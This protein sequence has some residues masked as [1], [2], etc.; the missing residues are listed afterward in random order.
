M[1]GGPSGV[2][3]VPVVQP[4]VAFHLSLP[5]EDSA[6]DSCFLVNCADKGA[7]NYMERER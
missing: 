2:Y 3:F 4:V 7:W 6:V 5:R 1:A